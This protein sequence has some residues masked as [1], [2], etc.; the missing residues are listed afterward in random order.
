MK[1]VFSLFSSLTEKIDVIPLRLYIKYFPRWVRFF[2]QDLRRDK[3]L[4]NHY[5][6]WI[7]QT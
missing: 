2:W 6:K 1:I 3:L 4:E 7:I 5:L